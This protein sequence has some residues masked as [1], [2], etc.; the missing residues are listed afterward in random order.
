MLA[1]ERGVEMIP[2]EIEELQKRFFCIQSRD[3]DHFILKIIDIFQKTE[4]L[5]KCRTVVSTDLKT[6][7][8]GYN[9]P[10]FGRR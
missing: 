4:L 2:F 6:V 8:H 9:F 10:I 5:I 7:G 1:Y 3:N